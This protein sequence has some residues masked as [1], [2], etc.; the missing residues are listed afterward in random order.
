ME[1]VDEVGGGDIK[2]RLFEEC[3]EMG[4]VDRR[5]LRGNSVR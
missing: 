5:P 2:P 4:R 3:E 1:E